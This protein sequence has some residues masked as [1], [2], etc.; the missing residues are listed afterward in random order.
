MFLS[1]FL[2]PALAWR[3]LRKVWLRWALTAFSLVVLVA[4][5]SS[6]YLYYQARSRVAL[7]PPG[8]EYQLID[9]R[10][11]RLPLKPEQWTAGLYDLLAPVPGPEPAMNEWHSARIV[12]R[13]G[14]V[15]HWLD[16]RLTARFELGS[17]ALRQAVA[18]SK[19][20]R[21]PGFAEPRTG[22]L[23]LQTHDGR[24]AFRNI[25]VRPF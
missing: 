23:M 9:N 13:G 3:L 18:Q 20:R 17:P 14:R 25:R 16:G 7:T 6:T 15:E 12:V 24:V 10:N 5:L 21:V 1:A 2:I 22:Y 11:Y 19:F 4:A 8:F